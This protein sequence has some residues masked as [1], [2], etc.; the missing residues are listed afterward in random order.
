M[1]QE[2]LPATGD[3]DGDGI[4]SAGRMWVDFGV[5]EGPVAPCRVIPADE[6]P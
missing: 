4:S 3:P 2:V 1:S 6:A 5:A